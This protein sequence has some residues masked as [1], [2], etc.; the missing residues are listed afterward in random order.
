MVPLTTIPK[1]KDKD[2]L[3]DGSGIALE[4]ITPDPIIRIGADQKIA[5]HPDHV[6][7]LEMTMLW[8][9]LWLSAKLQMTKNVRNTARQANALN[10]ESRDILFATVLT[11]RHVLV[12][13]V[14]FK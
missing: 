10:V 6:F 2:K 5:H 8:I 1:D 14:Q 4:A 9:L 13:L 11:R 3:L 7:L 12:Q